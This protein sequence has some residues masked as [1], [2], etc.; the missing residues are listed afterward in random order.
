MWRSQNRKI[1]KSDKE[2]LSP[3]GIKEEE[4]DCTKKK[5]H[6]KFGSVLDILKH[7]SFD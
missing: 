3:E 1:L 4:V 2:N 5:S 7:F 6:R